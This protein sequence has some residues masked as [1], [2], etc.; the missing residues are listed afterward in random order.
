MLVVKIT[1][2][3]LSVNLKKIALFI[4][5]KN[6]TLNVIWCQYMPMCIIYMS[7]WWFYPKKKPHWIRL[8]KKISLTLIPKFHADRKWHIRKWTHPLAPFSLG[9]FI[10]CNTPT[11]E[12]I[13]FYGPP[14]R[15]SSWIRN[16]LTF[17]KYQNLGTLYFFLNFGLEN[18]LILIYAYK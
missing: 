8:L 2:F 15:A 9:F 5:S 6:F 10:S 14:E 3:W 11:I 7:L 16:F 13:R 18:D 12:N 1:F 17:W 4:S